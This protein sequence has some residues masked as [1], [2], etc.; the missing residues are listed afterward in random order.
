MTVCGVGACVGLRYP[1]TWIFDN[2]VLGPASRAVIE[3][4]HSAPAGLDAGLV[5]RVSRSATRGRG[6]RV[7]DSFLLSGLTLAERC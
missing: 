5:D 6:G 1:L 4:D 2:Q 7:S 3:G